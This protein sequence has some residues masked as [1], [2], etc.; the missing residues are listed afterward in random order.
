MS[1]TGLLAPA[2]LHKLE[3]AKAKA[4]TMMQNETFQN[5]Q[6]VVFH[7]FIRALRNDGKY[8]EEEI[9]ALVGVAGGYAGLYTVA[10]L[11]GLPFD[12]V[13]TWAKLSLTEEQDKPN[14]ERSEASTS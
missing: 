2:I 5:G 9:D 13:D 3:E 7:S 14:G 4:P 1:N 10:G 11:S 12:L 8:T 6:S